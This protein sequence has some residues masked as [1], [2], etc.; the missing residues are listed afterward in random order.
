MWKLGEDGD[1][2]EWETVETP[3]SI[4]LFGVTQTTE[5]PYAVG[6]GGTLVA[7]RGNG[8]EVIFDDGPNTR[9]NQMR[10]MDV[11]D[12]GQ[13]IWMLGSSGSMACYDVEQ[14]RKYDYS[15]PNE[16]T[17]TWE[18][19]TV[20]GNRGT[21][22]VL[23]ANGSGEVLPFVVDGFDVD[24]GQLDK[25]A[26]KGSNVA[27]LASTP[28][29]VGYA[30]DTSGN[31]FKTTPEEGWKDI[32][33]VN[34]QVKFYDVYAGENSRVYVAAGD[35]RIYRYDDSYHN[36][37]PIGVT[38]STSLR[39]IDVY[40]AEDGAR[41]MVVLGADGSIYQRTGKERWEQIPSPT[42]KGLRALSLGKPDVAVG[43]GGTVIKR[44][45]KRPRNAGDSADGDQFDGRGESDDGDGNAPGETEKQDKQTSAD[46]SGRAGVAVQDSTDEVGWK[47]EENGGYDP[48]D[49]PDSGA[50][51]P[52][53]D[54]DDAPDSGTNDT[55]DDPDDAPD[56]EAAD[57]DRDPD[58]A[59]DRDS[60]DAND[61]DDADDSTVA[62]GSTKTESSGGVWGGS[63]ETTT[64]TAAETAASADTSGQTDQQTREAVLVTLAERT[65][66]DETDI[67]VATEN[68]SSII[69][70]VLVEIAEDVDIDPQRV[71]T[72]LDEPAA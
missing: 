39:A 6:S 64:S 35:G 32:G 68:D 1:T 12:D 24:W 25:P 38:D 72:A 59:D 54:P 17:S 13:R 26:G 7:D 63:D 10:A 22:K 11:T 70:E 52:D 14:R 62:S 43:K 30:I 8:W 61:A 56:G 60:N 23:A 36:W 5:G 51:D 2:P 44:P 71:R 16:M 20:S 47:T 66:L 27:A 41:Q 48:D 65:N 34:A 46:G 19:I 29:G 18:G 3:F 28:D 67:E 37:T 55:D 31:A 4:S 15:Y 69:E 50:N 40:T 57:P 33:I 45:R 42:S 9:D 21:E 53:E 58:D 49:S